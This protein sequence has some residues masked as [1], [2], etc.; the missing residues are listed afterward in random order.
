MTT[1]TERIVWWAPMAAVVVLLVGWV[2][3]GGAATTSSCIIPAAAPR[4]RTCVVAQQLTITGRV[5]RCVVPCQIDGCVGV[6]VSVLFFPAPVVIKRKQIM[7]R[8]G[9]GGDAGGPAATTTVDLQGAS[10]AVEVAERL[11]VAGLACRYNTTS[12]RLEMCATSPCEI[13]FGECA[14][15]VGAGERQLRISEGDGT[16]A[17]RSGVDLYGARF[18]ECS[19]CGNV[20]STIASQGGRYPLTSVYVPPRTSGAPHAVYRRQSAELSASRTFHPQMLL[21]PTLAFT[22]RGPDGTMLETV[23]QRGLAWHCVLTVY[24]QCCMNRTLA[25]ATP[26]VHPTF[27]AHHG[28][29][30]LP[31]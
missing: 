21:S 19:L 3:F 20:P 27:S 29:T 17:M 12:H 24:S 22:T 6:E 25:T 23:P 26:P 8:S 15:L 2:A 5:S 10:N 14:G 16:V 4:R 31:R 7:I 13:D 9:G 18:V 28:D 1:T 11:S 30:A